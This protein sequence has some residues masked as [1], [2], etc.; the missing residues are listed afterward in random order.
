MSPNVVQTISDCFSEICCRMAM[1]AYK[2]PN[3]GRKKQVQGYEERERDQIRSILLILDLKDRKV[4]DSGKEKA[5]CSINCML[6]GWMM[7]CEIEIVDYIFWVKINI[8]TTIKLYKLLVMKHWFKALYSK[9]HQRKKALNLIFDALISFQ[10]D[11][12]LILT[13]AA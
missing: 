4:K 3:K 13:K 2:K 10:K 7:I 12:L 1:V 11:G 6:L 9:K 5:R 8:K